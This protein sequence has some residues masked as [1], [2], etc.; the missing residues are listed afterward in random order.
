MTRAAGQA[1]ADPGD[2]PVGLRRRLGTFS[3]TARLLMTQVIVPNPCREYWGDIREA[4]SIARRRLAGKSDA[5]YLES[6]N[7]LLASLGK[8]GRDFIDLLIGADLVMAAASRARG[9][10]ARTLRK[11]AS[12]LGDK[13]VELTDRLEAAFSDE[14][15]DTMDAR[16][17]VVS[18]IALHQLI[19]PVL[20]R[21]ALSRAGEIGKMD[22]AR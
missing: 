12:T 4:G 11:L 9:K 16:L 3:F 20:F 15:R 7:G 21:A 10:S 14:L 18:L 1:A 22:A 13:T 8:Q 5:A 6:G 2:A 17:L 19:G